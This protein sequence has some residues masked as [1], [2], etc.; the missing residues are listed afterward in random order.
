MKAV[1]R[2]RV[3]A[4]SGNMGPG[5]DTLGVALRL[6]NRV[7]T[8]LL[9][10]SKVRLVGTRGSEPPSGAVK[11]IAAATRAFFRKIGIAARGVEV[12]VRGDVPTARGLGSSV[13]VRLGV[14]VGLNRLLGR[15]L[16]E[17][18][19][20]D[21][22][23]ALEGHPDNAAPALL[24]GMTVAGTAEGRVVAWRIRVPRKLKFVA[25]IPDYEV[26]TRA[27]RA[28]LPARISFADAAHNAN[29]AALVVAAMR[30][31]DYV[32]LGAFLEDRL[33]Q[34]FRAKLVPQLFPALE[35]AR[36]A[37]A[38]GGWLSGSGSTVMALTLDSP[39]TV[40]RAMARA[41]R[42]GGARCRILVLESD[43]EGARIER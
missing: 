33:H 4:T 14:L 37:G 43:A 1:V 13:T 32:R 23:A 36:R 38:I 16:R 10:T 22:V 27:A 34:P 11:M 17:S 8:R 42:R 41:F 12:S 35:A 2:V 26:E 7:E 31:G 40:G 15:P 18:D 30:A 20:L 21:L 28:L 9:D 5:F 39:Q 19:L 25:A 24:G 3:P 29:R 6:Y